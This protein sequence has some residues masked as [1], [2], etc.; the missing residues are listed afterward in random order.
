MENYIYV[1]RMN[2]RS[3][4]RLDINV[5]NSGYIISIQFP[6]DINNAKQSVG[7]YL[8]EIVLVF[9]INANGVICFEMTSYRFSALP[10]ELG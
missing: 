9:L 2:I 3:H 7:M 5:G 4:H 1:D 8:L 10:D 6:V